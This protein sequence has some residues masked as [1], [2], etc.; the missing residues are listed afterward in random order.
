MSGDAIHHAAMAEIII[1]GRFRADFLRKTLALTLIHFTHPQ[2][3]GQHRRLWYLRRQSNHQELHKS[4]WHQKGDPDP[5]R[6]FHIK[7]MACNSNSLPNRRLHSTRSN[8]LGRSAR[9][10]SRIVRGSRLR[11]PP[12]S[13]HIKYKT[14]KLRVLAGLSGTQ[15]SLL[16]IS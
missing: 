9:N 15:A 1:C 8:N 11:S 10:P 16:Q 4:A 7:N 12:G 2:N 14:R 3:N 13:V 6:L 5:G